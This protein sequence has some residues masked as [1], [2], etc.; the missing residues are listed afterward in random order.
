MQYWNDKKHY[1]KFNY[2][3]SHIKGDS[4]AMIAQQE[5]SRRYFQRPDHDYKTFDSTR[6]SM[7]GHA[8]TVQ[9]GKNGSSKLRWVFWTT[10]RSP[11][12]E[13]NDIGFL[14]RGDA[15]FQVFWAGDRGTEPFS[16]F[17]QMQVNINQW[18]GWDFGG[19][20]NFYGG[21]LNTW[22]Q[23]KNHWS[24]NAGTNIDGSNVSN[25]RLRGGP[26][27]KTPG[28][29]N[30]WVGMGMDKIK[31]IQLNGNT[32]FIAGQFLTDP[33]KSQDITQLGEGIFES[34][35]YTYGTYLNSVDSSQTEPSVTIQVIIYLYYDIL[36]LNK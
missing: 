19:N 27:F 20:N 8:G 31:K 9:V 6:T 25:T 1:F 15:I 13:T 21:N 22:M 34:Y 24:F 12:F 5:S 29:L 10:W 28:S 23:F 11:E 7:T 4:V 36:K 16:I 14:T 35:L 17:G 2:A 32:G 30:Y 18:S 26:S 33:L 3:M